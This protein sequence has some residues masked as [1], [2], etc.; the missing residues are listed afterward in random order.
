LRRCLVRKGCLLCLHWR[1]M[2]L[3]SCLVAN[4]YLPCGT[5]MVINAKLLLWCASHSLGRSVLLRGWL[6]CCRK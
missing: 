2:S 3:C 5:L 1:L 6:M 4:M